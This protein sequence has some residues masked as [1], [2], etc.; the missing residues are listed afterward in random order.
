M[1]GA[2]LAQAVTLAKGDLTTE[3]VKEFTELQG[4]VGGLYARAEGASELVS[5]AIYDQ[6]MPAGIEGRVPRSVEGALLGIADRIDTL[7]GL[8]GLGLEPTGSK[9]P[10]GLRR[11]ANAVIKILA[12]IDLPLRLDEIVRH[13][14]ADDAAS[15]RLRAFFAERLST[16]LREVRGF[17]YDVVAAV[18]ASDADDIRDAAARAEAVSAMRG[19]A[20]FLAVSAAIKRVR[21]ILEQAEAKGEQIL[22]DASYA[23][24]QVAEQEALE[25]KAYLVGARVHGHI[26]HGDYRSALEAMA[27]LRP[28]IDSFF[29]KVMVM[30]PDPQ[31]RAQRLA[32]LRSIVQRFSGIADFSEIVTAG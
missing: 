7:A 31:L 21:N 2:A 13:A 29:N 10:F 9:D 26:E 18:L 8:F 4:I 15:V 11:A 1:D 30:D 24:S 27:T 32:L 12:E 28:E 6:Y 5:A 25:A 3:L 22:L 14:G 16:Y 20:D 17:A 19:S 23:A